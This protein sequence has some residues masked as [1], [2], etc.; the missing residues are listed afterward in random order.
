MVSRIKQTGI[1]RNQC[2]GIERPFYSAKG[3]ETPNKSLH[4]SA[5]APSEELAG[6]AE[7]LPLS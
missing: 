5:W 4:L 6:S 1:H 3:K 2:F 7:A